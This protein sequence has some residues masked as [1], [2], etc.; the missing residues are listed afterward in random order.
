ME[1]QQ[2]IA[3]ALVDALADKD[4]GVSCDAAAALQTYGSNEQG[5]LRL[6]CYALYLQSQHQCSHTGLL[7][8]SPVI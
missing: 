8:V 6:S 1:Q 4:T 7:L 2:R 5:A 3:G